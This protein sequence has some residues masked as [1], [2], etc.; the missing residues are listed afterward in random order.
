MPVEGFRNRVPTDG[1]L[2][3]VAGRWSACGWSMAV[4]QLDHDEE[5]EPM[6][7]MYGTLDAELEVQRTIQRA[8][9]T[10]FLCLTAHVENKGI[11]DGALERR[12]EVHWP[13]SEGRRLVDSDL[14][15]GGAD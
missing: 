15:G 1:S 5:M 9:L 13:Q 10:A 6:H 12:N 14:G 3:E 7:S 4:V 8:E 11:I 2:L